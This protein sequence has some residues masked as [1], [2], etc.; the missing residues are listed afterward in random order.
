M[1]PIERALIES[2]PK[3]IRLFVLLLPATV[4]VIF[5]FTGSHDKRVTLVIMACFLAA[6]AVVVH[7]ARVHVVVRVALIVGAVGSP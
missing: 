6:L 1:S 7:L 2:P 5:M 3:R 4:P